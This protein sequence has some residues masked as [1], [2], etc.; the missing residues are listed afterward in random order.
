MQFGDFIGNQKILARLGDKLREGRLPH[1]L[2]VSGP[3][4]VGKHT[5]AVMLA[6]TLN[7]RMAGSGDFCG[8]CPSC[9]KIDA[10]T[11]PD[12]MTVSVE[13]DATQIKI[14]Q[15]RQM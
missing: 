4:G 7:C 13:E 9:R 3:E 12:V 10:R 11:H 14:G 6:K 1:G 15:V 5:L 8:A 2:I